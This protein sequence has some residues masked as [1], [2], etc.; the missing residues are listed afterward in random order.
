MAEYSRH[1]VDALLRHGNVEVTVLASR[2]FGTRSVAP[3]EQWV[4]PVFDVQVW[5]PAHSFDLDVETILELELDVLHV[6]Y[7]NLSSTAGA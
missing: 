1:L 2:N 4:V 3:H 6:Q 5:H 7:S